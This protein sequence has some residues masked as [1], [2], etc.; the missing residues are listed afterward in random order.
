MSAKDE[1]KT[2][3][4]KTSTRSKKPTETDA[5]IEAAFIATVKDMVGRQ[6]A[7]VFVIDEAV[8][9]GLKKTDALANLIAL[10]SDE[11]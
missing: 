8:F 4:T 5:M 7:K 11:E 9:I 10:A 6:L 3:D 1:T 2:K